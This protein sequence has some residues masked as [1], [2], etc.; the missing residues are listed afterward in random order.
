M[1]KLD[2]PSRENFLQKE[3]T[4]DVLLMYLRSGIVQELLNGVKIETL[5]RKYLLMRCGGRKFRTYGILRILKFKAI[6]LRKIV[7]CWT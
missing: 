4:G 1:G 7:T 2:D 5:G 3:G 6:Q